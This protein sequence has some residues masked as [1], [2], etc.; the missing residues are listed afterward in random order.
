M[1][2]FV[3]LAGMYISRIDFSLRSGSGNINKEHTQKMKRIFI[4]KKKKN[5]HKYLQYQKPKRRVRC[6]GSKHDTN[7]SDGN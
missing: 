6:N 4:A 7:K 3:Y 5:N 1:C 2:T